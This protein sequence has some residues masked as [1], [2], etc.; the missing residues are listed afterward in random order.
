ML[1]LAEKL[2]GDRELAR[3]SLVMLWYND[4]CFAHRKTDRQAAL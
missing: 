4:A 2:V 3:T 1:A